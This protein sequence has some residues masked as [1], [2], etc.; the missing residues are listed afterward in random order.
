MCHRLLPPGPPLLLR[1]AAEKVPQLWRHLRLEG[2]KRGTGCHVIPQFCLLDLFTDVAHAAVATSVMRCLGSSDP[3]FLWFSE[4]VLS[5]RSEARVYHFGFW[6]ITMLPQEVLDWNPDLSND[7][8][9]A[10]LW[11]SPF[12]Y[13]VDR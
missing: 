3:C 10:R 2:P 8:E 7:V 5:S 12:I 4:D 11:V 1:A 6:L 13:Q 9:P